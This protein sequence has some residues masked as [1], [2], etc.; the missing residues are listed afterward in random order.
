MKRTLLKATL[1]PLAASLLAACTSVSLREQAPLAVTQ[2]TVIRDV[3]VVDTRT[4]ALSP[5]MLV[6]LEGDRIA[7]IEPDRPVAAS[8]SARVVNASGRYLVPGFLDMHSH[9][10]GDPN[11][12]PQNLALMLANGITGFREMAGSADIIARARQLNA[13]VAAGRVAAPQALAVPGELFINAT[14][15]DAAIAEVRR[16]KA[17]GAEFIK[18]ISANR[19]TSLAILSEAHRQ[20][21]PVAGHLSLPLSAADASDAGWHSIEHLGAGMGFL[22]ECSLNEGAIRQSIL[23]GE[24]ART[25]PF[26]PAYIN[27]PM[28]FRGADV[29]LY[30]RILDSYS[31]QKCGVLA[32]RFARNGTWNVPTLIRLRTI[33]TSGDLRFANDPNLAYIN[34]AV[35]KLWQSLGE[36][37]RT[38][39]SPQA[40]KT[41]ADYYALQKKTVKLL[42]QRGVRMLAGSDSGGAGIWMIPG[43]SLHQEFAELA[44]AG[45][46]PLQILQM[47]TLNG[48]QYLRKEGTMGTV[49]PG[50]NADLVLLDGNPVDSSANLDRIAGV[51]LKGRWLPRATLEE[52]KREVAAAR[53]SAPPPGAMQQPASPAETQPVK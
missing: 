37:Y 48:A 47:T 32:D 12:A 23:N 9:G 18:L 16:Q 33:E 29:P 26:S 28:L 10:L 36:Q 46:T 5:H 42:Q 52:M 3:T 49:E 17:M 27:S 1:L 24:G 43:F 13:D 34:P 20:G 6:R 45:L 39:F 30:Q 4:G 50:K 21:L 22:L 15:P 35:V 19:D 25:P 2:G 51:F 14:S 38:R 11:A 53:Q 44:S 7:G 41:L 8:G 40:A 31:E